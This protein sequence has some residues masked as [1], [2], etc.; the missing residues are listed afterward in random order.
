MTADFQLPSVDQLEEVEL[1]GCEYQSGLVEIEG[2]VSTCNQF[3]WEHPKGYEVHCF[4]LAAWRIPGNKI[5]KSRL[6]VLRALA[7]ESDWFAEYAPQSIH[8]IIV[9]LSDDNNRAILANRSETL[10]NEDG[11]TEIAQ[12]LEQLIVLHHDQFGEL[13]FDPTMD[14]F[15]CEADWNGLSVQLRFETDESMEISQ[16]LVTAESLWKDQ[17]IW[18]SRMDQYIVAELLDLKNGTWLSK[19]ELPLSAEQ[20]LSRMKFKSISLLAD[21]SFEFWYDDGDLFWGHSIQIS[22]SLSE[23]LCQATIAG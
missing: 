1:S 4:T 9:K 13:L 6:T 22:G 5:K 21:G 18:K 14:W 20:F 19:G 16:G 23:G 7:P 15:T 10:V 17:V 2:V 8:R 11:L 3:G 12:E